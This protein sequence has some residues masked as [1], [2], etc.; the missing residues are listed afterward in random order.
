[1][2]NIFIVSQ[3]QRELKII[4]LQLMVLFVLISFFVF[5][6]WF[7]CCVIFDK[8]KFVFWYWVLTMLVRLLSWNPYPTKTSLQL[9]QLMDSI[10]KIYLM[11][12]AS[13]M[14]G[15]LVVKRHLENT[16]RTISRVLMLLSSLLTL[17]I[18][19]DSKNQVKNL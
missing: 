1:M 10:L 3:Y 6:V 18:P 11:M 9:S 17:L 8:K 7:R 19:R 2:V 4:R 15:M 12:A 16:G 13:L 14:S 5:R